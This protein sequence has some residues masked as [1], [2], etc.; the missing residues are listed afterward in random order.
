MALVTLRSASV[1]NC[2][3]YSRHSC[4]ISSSAMTLQIKKIGRVALEVIHLAR[5]VM[6]PM[7]RFGCGTSRMSLR[8]GL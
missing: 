1:A 8:P 2:L 5:T 7:S 4:Q 3:A 6:A